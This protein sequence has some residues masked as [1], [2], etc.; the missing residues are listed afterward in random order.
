MSKNI[1]P[2]LSALLLAVTLGASGASHADDTEIYFDPPESL[3][4]AP[5]VF[6]YIEY[7][8]N[9]AS[10]ICTGVTIDNIAT[11]CPAIASIQTYMAAN[12]L[13]DGTIDQF[14]LTRA[15]LKRVLAGLGGLKISLLMAHDNLANCDGGP[16]TTAEAA[17]CSQGGYILQGLTYIEDP[18]DTFNAATATAAQL[19]AE[20]ALADQTAKKTLFAKLDALPSP[21]G[22][23]SHE[24]QNKEIY[25]ELFRYLTGQGVYNGRNGGA[26]YNTSTQVSYN[27]GDYNDLNP[28]GAMNTYN[29]ALGFTCDATSVANGTA[30]FE[31]SGNNVKGYYDGDFAPLA[32]PLYMS[33]LPLKWDETIMDG[34]TY[35]AAL[36]ENCAKVFVIN[37]VDGGGN[38][39]DDANAAINAA[40]SSG[41]FGFTV[42]NSD[43]GFVQMVDWLHDVDLADGTF[44]T[45]GT[46]LDKQ[47]VTSFFV[48]KQPQQVDAAAAAGGSNYAIELGPDAGSVVDAINKIFNQVVSVSTTFVAASMPVNAFN[49]SSVTDNVYLALFQAN[50]DVQPYWV[51]NLKKLKLKIKTTCLEYDQ[52]SGD[53]INEEQTIILVDAI[54]PAGIE[55]SAIADDGRIMKD[56]LTYWTQTNGYDLIDNIDPDLEIS[57]RDGRAVHRGG[58]G[59][60]IP[61]FITTAG[62]QGSMNW[63][64]SSTGRRLYTEAKPYASTATGL[65]DIHWSQMYYLWP[66]MLNPTD[67]YTLSQWPSTITYSGEWYN[68]YTKTWPTGCYSYWGSSTDANPWYYS[69][70]GCWVG[71]IASDVIAY[72]RGYD[73]NARVYYNNGSPD[74]TSTYAAMKKSRRWLMGDPRHSRPRPINYG[75]RAGHTEE[76]PDIRIV[77]GSN[78]GYLRMI[79]NTDAVPCGDY[80]LECDS[81]REVWAFMPRAVMKIQ[82]QLMD[83]AAA[84]N[85]RHPY[86]VDSAPVEYIYDANRDGTLDHNVGDKVWIFFGLRRGGRAYYALDISDPDNP[87]MLWETAKIDNTLGDFVELGYSFAPPKVRMLKWGGSDTAR[88]ALIFGGGYD[89]HKDGPA[90]GTDDAM[91]RAVYVVNAATGEL[92]WKA[93]SSD[94][95]TD[96]IPSEVTTIDTN[97]DSFIDRFYVGDTGGQVWRA[98]LLGNDESQWTITRVLNVGRHYINTLENDR[99]FFYAPEVVSTVDH[100]GTYIGVVIG[101]GN[102]EHPLDLDVID[103]LYLYKD[104]NPTVPDTFTVL[105]HDSLQDITDNCVQQVGLDCS[106]TFSLENG[107]KLRLI[108]QG[109]KGLAS[110]LVVNNVVY[111]NSYVPVNS[112]SATSCGPDEGTGWYYEISLRDGRAVTDYDSTNSTVDADGNPVDLQV[113]DRRDKLSS[114]G[115]PA[116]NVYVSFTDGTNSFSGVLRPD[117]E[118]PANLG[119]AIYPTYWYER[120][121]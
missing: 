44:G 72:M 40:L 19:A 12:D 18:S 20:L 99:R 6:F 86:A 59:Q 43:T 54:P 28:A 95:L 27:L 41:G 15:S 23:F 1:R 14:E 120:Q 34:A 110:P 76:N 3:D 103:W 91:G 67:S 30:R 98:D 45:A 24:N 96:S 13:A 39:A 81:G 55:E 7:T 29:C 89:T 115:I 82:K 112:S 68:D 101:S 26:D 42:A 38:S 9:L 80:A 50:E 102:R 47:N 75:A 8:P 78:D 60:Q 79:R 107:W 108:D 66:S 121:K 58:A 46:L 106:A 56:A 35:R 100:L 17:L 97:G 109:E 52:A 2:L 116:E 104:R 22:G 114:A 113:E 5:L 69:I 83:N 62:A 32:N 111:F 25:F 57:G 33:T 36:T 53:C 73:T 64:N 77:M 70:G 65:L 61:N 4:Q 49:R 105:S 92:I 90:L 87:R 48:A 88:P 11:S 37:V 31:K 63:L 117:F 93:D 10:T 21:Q 85:P 118:P 16:L 74:Y 94:G 119:S 84:G 51:G 71:D